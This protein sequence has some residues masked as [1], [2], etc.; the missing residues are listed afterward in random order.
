MTESQ[1]INLENRSTKQAKEAYLKAGDINVK[2]ISR[3]A[4]LSK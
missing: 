1:V 2:I 3:L 4:L